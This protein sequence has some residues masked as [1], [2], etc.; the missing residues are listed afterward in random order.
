MKMNSFS[1][2][3]ALGHDVRFGLRTLA[4]NP[5]FTAVAVLTLALGV[6]ANTAI[7]SVVKAVLLDPL[8]YAEPDR[9][10]AI[11][12]TAAEAPENQGV[13]YTTFR[14]L[15]AHTRSFQ[16][17]SAFR[18]GAGTLFENGEP[19]K[20]RGLS[21]DYSFFDTLGVRMHLGRDFLPGEQQVGR[22]V[23]LILSHRLWT[24]QF[25]ADPHILGRVLHLDDSHL[26]VVGVLPP[27]FKPL[28]KATSELDPEMYYP[29]TLDPFT[30]CRTCDTVHVIGRLGRGVSP[31]AARAELDSLLEPIVRQ[32]PDAHL[33]GARTALSLLP[34]RILGRARVALWAVSGAVAFVLLIACANVANLLLARATGRARE[35]AVRSAIGAGRGRIVLLLLT[36]SLLLAVAG[37]AL[38]VLLGYGGTRALASL[39]PAQIPRAQ[40]AHVDGIVLA[41]ALAAIVLAGLLFGL[42]PAWRA[43][44]VDLNRAMKGVDAAGRTHNGL[45]N[46]LAVTEI[47]LAFVLAVGAGLMARTFWRL[48]SVDAGYDPRRVLTL[49]TNVSSPRYEGNLIGYYRDAL[50]RLRAVPGIE[51]VAMSSLIPMDYTQRR[52]F[53]RADRP[54]AND[55]DAP[56]ADEFSVSTD[57]FR[58]MRIPLK[59]GRLFTEQDTATTPRVALIGESCARSQFRGEDPIGKHIRLEGRAGT[60]PWMTVVGVVGDVRQ[61]GLDH[62]ADMQVYMA[63]NQEAIIGYYRMMARTAGEPMLLE[64]AVRSAFQAVDAGSPV[65]HVKS[66]EAYFSGRLADRTF[67]LALLGLLGGLALVLAAVGLYGVI[68]L[69]VAQRTREIGIRMALGAARCEVLTLVVRQALPLI[70]A[71]LGIGLAA[72]LVLTRW[73]ATLLFEVAPADPATS[74]AVAVLLA[75]VALAA[76]AVPARRAASLDPMAALR[77]E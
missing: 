22:R 77:T 57:Y 15:R 31:A 69:S 23:A 39:A 33:R 8:P 64:R 38:G 66:L 74:V 67:A 61:D 51:G 48:M 10:A 18:D 44:R 72:S 60:A 26:T 40:A 75:S 58:V 25:G 47:A 41:F 29:L 53:Y 65:Y 71:G 3:E 12:E 52:Q 16:S 49:T 56:F 30:P 7:F 1:S 70:G 20:L 14:E 2:F 19:E 4:R 68:S 45:R 32:A 36:E 73:L 37:G 43:S 34:N 76:T 46:G 5:A 9:L 11:A 55:G 35:I 13:D 63:L 28:I 17:M 50:D 21:V 54:L 42:A 59:R 27:D 62:A 24:R 6:G